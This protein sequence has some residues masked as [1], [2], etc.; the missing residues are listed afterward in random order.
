[1]SVRL[2]VSEIVLSVNSSWRVL[3][4]YKSDGA[5][6]SPR[7]VWILV[8]AAS[9]K[10]ICLRHHIVWRM[11]GRRRLEK[12]SILILSNARYSL[13]VTSY[14]P[15]VTDS[16]KMTAPSQCTSGEFGILRYWTA[17]QTR[18]DL[19]L[20]C[21]LAPWFSTLSRG[22]SSSSRKPLLKSFFLPFLFLVSDTAALIFPLVL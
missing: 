3:A 10:A 15:K 14:C 12:Y 16:E 8:L 13:P 18:I 6:L 7:L 21:A 17:G 19:F 22:G 2:D 9:I 1:M 11:E 4:N 5:G 20:A